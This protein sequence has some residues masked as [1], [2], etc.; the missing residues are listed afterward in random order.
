MEAQRNT[1][2]KANQG[3]GEKARLISEIREARDALRASMQAKIQH[4]QTL[5]LKVQMSET[6]LKEDWTSSAC[7]QE[8]NAA[9]LR[10]ENRN[11]EVRAKAET[12]VLRQN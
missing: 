1:D 6:K 7:E 12:D 5:R 9:R 2:H 10:Q 11:V 8:V 3:Q 4:I